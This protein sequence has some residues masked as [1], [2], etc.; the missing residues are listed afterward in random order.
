MICWHFGH[1]FI[2]NPPGLLSLI[3]IIYYLRRNFKAQIFLSYIIHENLIGE[4]HA[5]FRQTV[6][7]LFRG[8]QSRPD[9]PL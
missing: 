5:F 7:S 4:V 9:L 3:S 1:I 8:H 6:T 2:A